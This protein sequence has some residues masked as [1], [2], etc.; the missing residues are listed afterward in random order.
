[1]AL[2][3]FTWR[4]INQ[5]APTTRAHVLTAQFGDGYKQ[6]AADGINHIRQSWTMQFVGS[7]AE[8]M[9]IEEFLIRHGGYRAFLWT[10]PDGVERAYKAREWSATPQGGPVWTLQTTFEQDFKP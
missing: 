4:P 2:E 10:S 1:M 8:I 9:A 6:E 3:V 5:S 7:L